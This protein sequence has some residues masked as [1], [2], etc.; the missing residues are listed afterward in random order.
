[1]DVTVSKAT[2]S[3]GWPHLDGLSD[4]SAVPLAAKSGSW[5][6]STNSDLRPTATWTQLSSNPS[7]VLAPM[8]VLA[9]DLRCFWRFDDNFDDLN[10]VNTLS[11]RAAADPFPTSS[12]TTSPTTSPTPSPTT[13]PTPSPT[14]SPTTSP[15]SSPSPSPTTSP[16]RSPTPS[17][18]Q[19]PRGSPTTSPTQAHT[20]SACPRRGL[21][22]VSTLTL[23]TTVAF[24]SVGEG[25]P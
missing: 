23:V 2:L 16:T 1:M 17:P 6:T 14:T 22:V 10:D 9:D 20:S 4:G 3:S 13:S 19:S 18:T 24:R 8:V 15:T 11:L 25:I 12:P 5:T 21:V 7:R